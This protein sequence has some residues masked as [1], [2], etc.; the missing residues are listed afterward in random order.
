MGGR[1]R[2]LGF[3]R[4]RNGYLLPAQR[5]QFRIDLGRPNGY[6]NGRE[7]F[8]L[9]NDELQA[10]FNG[11]TFVYYAEKMSKKNL[12]NNNKNGGFITNYN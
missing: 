5:P 12:N 1:D 6:P 8:Y 10:D 9:Y 4:L 11:N 3:L 2:P 7:D